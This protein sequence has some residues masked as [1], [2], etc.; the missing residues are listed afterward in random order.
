MSI[1]IWITCAR[2]SQLS[3]SATKVPHPFARNRSTS[4][5]GFYR[6]NKEV[7]LRERVIQAGGTRS[8]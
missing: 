8:I 4:V 3:S 1:A 2:T 5:A 7:A 6:R